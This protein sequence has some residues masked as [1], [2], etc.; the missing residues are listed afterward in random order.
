LTLEV[1]TPVAQETPAALAT[2]CFGNIS[3]PCNDRL[4]ER[5]QNSS[6]CIKNYHFENISVVN[7]V[8]IY[9]NKGALS[10]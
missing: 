1:T 8:N 9:E 7:N 2:T 10:P 5:N 6:D 3:S 4:S